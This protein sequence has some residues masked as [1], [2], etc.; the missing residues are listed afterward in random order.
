MRDSKKMR[1]VGLIFVFILLISACVKDEEKI[2]D[3]LDTE[4]A[5]EETENKELIDAASE[6]EEIEKDEERETEQIGEMEKD[7]LGIANPIQQVDREGLVELT[8]IPLKVPE[9]AEE[10]SY[11]VI[12]GAIN[13]VAEVRFS[14]NGKEYCYRA[15]GTGEFEAADI[16]G[17][18]YEWTETTDIEVG[19]CA[20]KLYWR[21][22]MCVIAW[23]DIAPGINYTLSCEK[24]AKKDE[25][26]ALA[27]ELFV[28]VQGDAE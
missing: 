23:I 1:V 25:L 19:Y 10:V 5:I 9:M 28:G 15:C 11:I 2:S 6:T 22:G 20:G 16:S 18:Y 7:G 17:L 27:N 8:G 26:L 3:V 14:Y 24:D 12:N 4:E 21:E 13:P